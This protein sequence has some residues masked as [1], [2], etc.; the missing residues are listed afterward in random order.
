MVQAGPRAAAGTN[1]E[2]S[3]LNPGGARSWL[4]SSRPG[5]A[6]EQMRPE[7]RRQRLRLA[8]NRRR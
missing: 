6:E 7:L 8:S 4:Q 3:R 2:G 1:L 5:A